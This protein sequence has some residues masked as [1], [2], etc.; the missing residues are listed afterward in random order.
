MQEGNKPVLR[1]LGYDTTADDFLSMIFRYA[2]A[3]SGI[4]VRR[5]KLVALFAPNT[6]EALAVRYAAHLLGAATVYLSAPPS[7]EGRTE[8]VAGMD[9]DLLVLFPETAGLLPEGVKVRTYTVGIDLPQAALRLD[10][11]AASESDAP[12]V[13]QAHPDDLAVIV[14]SG[15]TTGL[16]KGSWRTFGTYTAMAHVPSPADRRQLVNDCLAY[17]S[18]VLVDM[19]LLGGGTVVL[20]NSYEPADTLAMIEAERITDLFLVEPQLFDLMDHPDVPCRD[21]SSLRSITHIGASAPPTLRRRAWERLGPVIA[22]TYGASEMGLVSALSPAEQ[23]PAHPETFSCSGRILPGVGIRFR[24]TDGTLGTASEIGSI[25][26]R[27][28]AMAGGYRNRPELEARAFKDGWYCSGD[29]GFIDES[30]W[31]QILGRADDITWIDGAMVSPTLIEDAL[32]QLPTV[33]YAVVVVGAGKTGWV[34]AVVPWPGTTIDLA[35]CRDLVARRLHVFP[36]VVEVASVPLTEQG[37]PDREAI[38]RLG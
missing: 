32:C 33:R 16:P 8:L 10:H 26:V 21:L 15:G 35:Q 38:R 29:L 36:L 31:L 14:C 4:D 2:R 18:Q 22:H 13:S 19:T 9:P 7:P 3:L 24:K 27:S 25:E 11:L 6:P 5:G 12:V 1:Y 34:A 23:D 20:E 37:K 28:P 30:G 17:L